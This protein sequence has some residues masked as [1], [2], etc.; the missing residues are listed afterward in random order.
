MLTKLQ[1]QTAQAIVNVFE[2]GRP[3]GDYGKVTLLPGDS[4]HL[5]YGRAQT[6]LASGNLFLLIK[7]YC[8]EPEAAYARPLTGYLDRLEAP[9]LSLD[10][11]VAFR[12]LLQDAGE[13]PVM[14]TAQD[15]FFDRVYWEPS[16]QSA[17][18]LGLASPLATSVVYDSKIH[19]SWHRMRDRAIGAHGRPD[20]IG[21]QPWV[22]AYIATRRG[23]LA[24]HSNRLLRRTVYR[25]DGFKDLIG[26]RKWT[27][28]LP[29]RV[30]GVEIARS[31]FESTPPSR[32]SA[33]AAV[34]VLSLRTPMQ[35]GDDVGAVQQ[36]LAGLGVVVEVDQIYGPETALAI[37]AFQD[38]HGLVVDGVVGPATRAALGL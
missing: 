30:H 10:H 1:K 4:G 6:T 35:Q 25:M 13:D 24:G 11:D 29:I 27:L 3:L 5:T 26:N 19:G 12:L 2:T 31:A 9:D 21:E 34:R 8:A 14:Q 37:R 23:W 22:E 38:Q 15:G 33:D 17:K 7:A 28:R 20:L 36:A 18:S 16:L 32:P